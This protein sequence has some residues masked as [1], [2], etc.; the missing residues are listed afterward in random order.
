VNHSIYSYENEDEKQE[1]F[2]LEIWKNE[3]LIILT[4]QKREKYNYMF[5]LTHAH[6]SIGYDLLRFIDG[7]N[8]CPETIIQGT[9]A[10]NP[11]HSLWIRQDQLLLNAIHGSLYISHNNVIHC[12][13]KNIIGSLDNIG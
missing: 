10:P 4:S 8:P 5:S 1:I 12:S 7:L 2:F 11:A 6:T 3:S 9:T 13:S